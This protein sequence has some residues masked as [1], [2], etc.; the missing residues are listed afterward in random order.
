MRF[1]V[2]GSSGFVGSHLV[3][4]LLQGQHRV[5]VLVRGETA[6]V[7]NVT[8]VKWDPNKDALDI[9]LL[10]GVD[11]VVHLAGASIAGK[12][13]NPEYKA[14]LRDSRVRGTRLLA[15]AIAGLDSPPKVMVSA[16]AMGYYGDRG[17]EVLTEDS[18]P[19]QGFLARTSV[20]WE[21]ATAPA[22]DA[23][24]RVVH[25]RIGNVLGRDGG[26]IKR[27]KP[28]F[29]TGLGGRIGSGQQWWPWI[30]VED[31]VRV[32]TTVVDDDSYAGAVNAAAPG[33]TRQA[34]FAKAMASALR[35]PA[36]LPMPAWLAR[37]MIGEMAQEA[38]LSSQRMVP[39]K[40]NSKGF[41][42]L[43]PELEVVFHHIF[44][45]P[46]ESEWQR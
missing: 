17:D 9:S 40:L 19:G 33:I 31:L 4:A 38:V 18:A 7:R 42:F 23:G 44:R 35:R 34:D 41:E 27:L 12:R 15:K 36:F 11:A 8:H 13:W 16:S 20:E 21:N 30:A 37:L 10:G 32:I 3:R 6:S 14:L 28:L 43:G 29:L 39:E 26:M 45:A 46:A 24:I 1:L 5:S 2:T 22:S 25:L